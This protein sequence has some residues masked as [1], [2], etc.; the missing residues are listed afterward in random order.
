MDT[1]S[2][3]DAIAPTWEVPVIGP[4]TLA[5]FEVGLAA[6]TGSAQNHITV[7]PS[8]TDTIMAESAVA[9]QFCQR[10]VAY[11]LSGLASVA[12]LNF[13]I[14]PYSQY[15]TRFI[16]P[17][18]N[19]SRA[20][21]AM[22]LAGTHP[23]PR[24]LILGSSRVMKLQPDY[25]EQRTGLKSFNAGVDHGRPE[26]FLAFWRFYQQQYG[27]YPSLLVVGLDI[28]AMS[29]AV[30]ID[31]RLLSDP[32]LGSLVPEASGLTG[33]YRRWQEL[34]SWQQSVSSFKA[35]CRASRLQQTQQPLESFRPDGLLIYH[36]REQ[37][38]AAGT[39]DFAAALDYN[40]REYL[41]LYQQFDQLSEIRQSLLARLAAECREVGTHLILFT[42]PHHPQ[43]EQFVCDRTD[44][45]QRRQ[46]VVNALQLLSSRYA[47]EFVD[48]SQIAAFTGDARGFVDGIHPLEANTRRMIDRLLD[49][50]QD[51]AP[52]AF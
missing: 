2:Q 33:R 39:Y 22:L 11:L 34:L 23:P 12:A 48:M 45:E 25:L 30:P 43:F 36:Q 46:E 26:D 20:E 35:C 19:P 7:S 37:E 40:Q 42:T 14:N 29:A 28:A 15:P 32:H 47:C 1:G 17:M 49:R 13:I 31:A 5:D 41:Q 16:P 8:L 18:V 24:A 51:G 6:P 4:P 50:P 38:L 9:R 44:Y 21:K 27:T 52:D 10:V 3:S